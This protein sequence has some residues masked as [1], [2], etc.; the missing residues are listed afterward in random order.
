MSL[1]KQI[2]H[3]IQIILYPVRTLVHYTRI[4]VEKYNQLPGKFIVLIKLNINLPLGDVYL[5]LF[6]FIN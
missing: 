3:L 6:S 5:C 4:I 2:R 1:I